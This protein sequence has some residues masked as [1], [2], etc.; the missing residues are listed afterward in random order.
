VIVE[1]LSDHPGEQLRRLE[2]Q[3]EEQRRALARHRADLD[4]L[5]GEQRASRRWWQLLRRVRDRAALRALDRR[6]PG[7]ERD[8]EGHRAQQTAG[9]RGEEAMTAAL[10]VLSDEWVLF[11]GY[12]NRRGEVDHLLVG[13]GG[14]WAI[15][16]KARAARVHVDG[17]HWWFEKFDRYGNRVEQGV[18]ADRRGRSWG[19]QVTEIAGELAAFLASRGQHVGVRSAVVVLHDRGELGS[20]RAL[21]VDLLCVGSGH[22]LHNVSAERRQLERSDRDAVAGLVRRDHAFHAKRRRGGGRG[23]RRRR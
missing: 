16:V 2:T 13:P 6:A 3:Q 9:I 14:V 11:R 20:C 5:R 17:D 1:V 18:L 12:A 23:R 15:E 7:L 10:S 19:R 22:L 8:L 21:G 4:R